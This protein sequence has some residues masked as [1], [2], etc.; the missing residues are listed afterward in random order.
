MRSSC[1][2]SRADNK[3]FIARVDPRVTAHAGDD[4]DLALNMNNAH[5]FDPRL[6]SAWLGNSS[7]VNSTVNSRDS[8]CWLGCFSM[9]GATISTK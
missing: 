6:R 5:I 3:Q 1:I 4:L 9:R 8:R 7:Y 2:W